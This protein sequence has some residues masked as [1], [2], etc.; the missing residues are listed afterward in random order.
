MDKQLS[1]EMESQLAASDG[2]LHGSNFVLMSMDA[3]RE[4]IGSLTS[5]EM[6]VSIQKL[7]RA[8][9]DA[10]QGNTRPLVE[11]INDLAMNV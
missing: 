10:N 8:M 5:E 2:I 4:T 7:N 3:Y 1:K 11:A 9:N 6:E